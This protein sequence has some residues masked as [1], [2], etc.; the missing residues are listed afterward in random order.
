MGLNL[1]TCLSNNSVSL[2][3]VG[4]IVINSLGTTTLG[5]SDTDIANWVDGGGNFYHTV[6]EHSSGCCWSTQNMTQ[7]QGIFS[8]LGWSGLGG[9]SGNVNSTISISQSVIDAITNNGGTLDYAGILNES[10]RTAS[11]GQVNFPSVCDTLGY[12]SLI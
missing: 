2:D 10:Y 1:S 7:A 9:L 4:I 5:Y 8:A 11:A 3:D 12:N 6:W